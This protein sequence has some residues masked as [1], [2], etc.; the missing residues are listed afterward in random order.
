MNKWRVFDQ[1]PKAP[2]NK[3]SAKVKEIKVKTV[4][5]TLERVNMSEMGTKTMTTTSI[6]V[7]IVIE[8]IVMGLTFHLETE[9][10]L[11]GMVE[12]VWRELR[13]CYRKC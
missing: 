11:V 12:V 2:T 10:F 5:T 1:T 8:M 13:I 6:R 7:T 3:I 4:V 9:M